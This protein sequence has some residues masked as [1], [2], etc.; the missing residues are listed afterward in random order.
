[1]NGYRFDL[2][3]ARCGGEIVHRDATEPVSDTRASCEA[4]C[5]E[6]PI[7]WRVDVVLEVVQDDSRLLMHD[8]AKAREFEALR[9]DTMTGA[10]GGQR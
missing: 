8:L 3:C 4:W 7:V 6:C 10:K 5:G 2:T 1:M 9:L